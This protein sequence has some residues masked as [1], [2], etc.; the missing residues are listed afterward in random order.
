MYLIPITSRMHLHLP[1]QFDAGR[2]E[3]QSCHAS[4]TWSNNDTCCTP[5]WIFYTMAGVQRINLLLN[6]DPLHPG[7]GRVYHRITIIHDGHDV[8]IE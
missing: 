8:V 7:L 5:H 4:M 3:F 6:S 2:V 1:L